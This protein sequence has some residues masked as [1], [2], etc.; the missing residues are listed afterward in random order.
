MEP[1]VA[2]LFYITNLHLYVLLLLVEVLELQG[3]LV[4]TDS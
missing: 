2:W 1:D 4:V 3:L